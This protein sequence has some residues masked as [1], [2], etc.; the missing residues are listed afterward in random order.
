M[1]RCIVKKI[2]P[3]LYSIRDPFNAF[4]YL[5]VGNERAL[6]FDTA[7]GVGGLPDAIREITDKPVVIALGHGHLDHVGGAYQFDEAWLREAD[8]DLCGRHSSAKA[9][10]R[11]LDGFVAGGQALPEGFDRGAYLQAGMCNLRKM[12]VGQEFD[13]GG[14]RMEAVDMGG[15]TAGSVGLLAREHRAL[16][17][18]DST[19]AH[20]W[21]FLRESL[22]VSQYVSM[23]ERVT[24]LDFDVFFAGHSDEPTPK[25]DF[26]K[27]IDAARNASIEKARP[28]PVFPEFGGW[29]YKEDGA[30]IVFH[31]DKL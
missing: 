13:L 23:L 24:R 11:A 29:L 16:L 1:K 26:Q 17:V 28:Y 18:S 6:L 27:Y 8:F 19:G 3:W 5:A 30:A 25:S 2:Y 12:E 7:H 22:S 31:A 14:L 10:G 15:H 21:M 4:C 20:V 9:R